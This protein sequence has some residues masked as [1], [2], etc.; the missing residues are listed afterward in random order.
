MMLVHRVTSLSMISRY[1]LTTG[2][3]PAPEPRLDRRDA[4]ADRRQRIVDLVHDAGGE[5]PHRGELFGLVHRPLN[6]A[7]FGHVLADRDHVRYG[8]PVQPHRQPRGAIGAHFVADVHV[9][10]ADSHLAGREDAVELR[11]EDLGRLAPQDLEDPLAD[12]VAAPQPLGAGLPL[13]IPEH[14]AVF[15]IHDVEP[16]RQ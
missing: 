1:S 15:V 12:H 3:T 7:R 11:L 13:A 16:D 6:G 2:S 8:R 14:D 10:L 9:L 4:P 5:L